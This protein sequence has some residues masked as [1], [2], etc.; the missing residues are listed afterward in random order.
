MK[1]DNAISN[2]EAMEALDW[3]WSTELVNGVPT[4]GDLRRCARSL[5]RE[6]WT[7]AK[8][9]Q[10]VV[11]TGGF[12]AV[13]DGDILTLEFVLESY[14]SMKDEWK[15]PI[16]HGARP[17]LHGAPRSVCGEVGNIAVHSDWAMVTC[18]SCLK[19]RPE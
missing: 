5:L 6:T 13:R 11:A 10:C 12:Q 18:A 16:V 14:T 4:L 7:T 9:G 15:P 8:D 1:D 19:D 3:K 17:L 2:A